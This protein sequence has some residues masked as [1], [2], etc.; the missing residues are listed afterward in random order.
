MSR[1]FTPSSTR[2]TRR[3]LPRLEALESRWCPSTAPAPAGVF[4]HGQTLVIHGD[5]S[6]DTITVTDDGKGDVSA[7]ITLATGTKSLS[8]TGIRAITIESGGGNDT[9]GYALTGTLGQAEKIQVC[10]D[11]GSSQVNLDFSAGVMDTALAVLF[12]GARG[13]NQITTQFGAITGS[14]VNLTENLGPAGA[15]THVNFGGALSGSDATVVINGGAAADQVFAEVGNETN[16]NLQFLTRLGNGANTFDLES[17]GNLV[18]SI[19]HFEVDGGSGGNTITFDAKGVNAD[20]T[21]RLN[22]H[23]YLGAGADNVTE[24]YSGVMD[25]ELDGVIATGAGA[26]TVNMNLTLDQGSTG[27]VHVRAYGN[28]G[29]DTM[30]FD[31]NDNSNPGGK[32]TLSLLDALLDGGA[33]TNTLNATPNVKVIK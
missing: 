11:K 20:L 30:T 9:I 16:A 13:S 3:C 33:G 26:D 21:S 22:L 23:A 18:N 10:L 7:S 24:N 2:S 31:V 17:T 28:K 1:S 12:T 29:D 15:T 4:Q 19:E 8:A 32:S 14:R 5:G 27:R 6:N 25:G